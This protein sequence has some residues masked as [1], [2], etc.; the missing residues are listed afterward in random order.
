MVE[1][2][3]GS[4]WRATTNSGSQ[5][6]HLSFEMVESYPG[7][8]NVLEARFGVVPD[9]VTNN[10]DALNAARD[11]ASAAG[12]VLYFP[13][14]VYGFGGGRFMFADGGDAY[15]EPGAILKLI[16]PSGVGGAVSGPY[17][18]QTKPIQVY[19]LTID[20]NNLPGENG[21]GFG[22]VTGASFHNLT[23]R[24][25]L[26][27]S[28]APLFGGKAL[29]FEGTTALN[30]QVFG[31]NVENCSIGIDIGAHGGEQS[32]HIGIFNAAMR[33]VDIPVHVNDTANA[34][35]IDHYDS[36]EVLIDGLHGRNCGRISWPGGTP[37]GGGIVASN[38][39]HRITV[40]NAQIVNDMGGFGSTAYGKIGAF[41]RGSMRGVILD[42]VLLVADAVALFDH[43][44]LQMQYASSDPM[45]SYVLA[46]KIR[47]YGDL[48]YIVKAP[49][50]AHLGAGKMVGIEIGSTQASLIGLV[51]TGAGGSSS[52]FLEVID[53]DAGSP[54]T[55]LRPLSA[56]YAAGNALTTATVGVLLPQRAGSWTPT[57]A[58]GAGLSLSGT[59][60]WVRHGNHVTLQGQ[61]TYPTTTN[62]TAAYI[63]GFPFPVL[64]SVA[65]RAGGVITIA[66]NNTT[67]RRIYPENGAHRAPILNDASSEIS[68]A[69]CSGA[70]IAFKIDYLTP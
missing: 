34:T 44:P 61:V 26:H 58:S 38:R 6:N 3:D 63:G 32:V 22:H 5:G 13:K 67:A 40:R 14:G 7:V 35:F 42:N 20:C 66:T 45:A 19:N 29:Q 70:T 18:D 2:V 39:G 25:C 27:N 57:D 50:A 55:G 43:A 15:F 21:I 60:Y 46:D 16:S 17:P 69:A 68:N 51:D 11:A 10:L 36:I 62:A 47:H 49:T 30:C 24:N 8:V 53:R 56:L 4:L 65:A 37:L 28:E 52:A 48:D 41:V 31:L 12:A 33:N 59:G 54:T 23:I 64:D 9:G 1:V